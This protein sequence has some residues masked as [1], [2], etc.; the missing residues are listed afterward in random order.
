MTVLKN[1]GP[2]LPLDVGGFGEGCPLVVVGR[3][4]L[5]TALQGGGA[6]RVQ[7]IREVHIADALRDRMGSSVAITDG[8][9]VAT[10]PVIATPGFV[11]DPVT[12]APGI[13][14]TSLDDAGVQHASTTN[15]VAEVLLGMTPGPHDSARALELSASVDIAE[16]TMVEVGVRGAGHWRLQVA[17]RTWGVTL[18][19]KSTNMGAEMLAPP[20]WVTTI[21]LQPGAVVRAVVEL[22]DETI[23]Y[24]GLIAHPLA[25]SDEQ[26]IRDAV[27][28]A[29][30]APVAVVVVGLTAEQ[31]TEGRDKHTLSLPGR[32]NDLVS[33]VAAVACRTVVVVNAAT[34]VLMP[35][36]DA[37]EAVLWAGLPGQEGGD[38][39]ADVLCGV[40]EA[41]G[42]LVTTFPAADG[43][44]PAWSTTP[45]DGN[46]DYAEGVAV[47]YRGWDTTLT[48]P[49][50]WFGHGL[51]W[52]SWQYGPALYAVEDSVE[53]V[54][55]DVTNT[56]DRTG[57]EVVQIY[58][59]PKNEPVRLVG[60]TVLDAQPP[61]ICV[62]AAVKLDG[63]AMRTWDEY[64][65]E[66]KPIEGGE[67][68]I[69]RGLGDVRATTA[70]PQDRHAPDTRPADTL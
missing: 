5:R 2:L 57:R 61:G 25:I 56:G 22:P 16:A 41:S 53:V 7:A 59:R 40:T 23:R 1:D 35:W 4:A 45:Q 48:P 26:A 3:A 70:R 38:A 17:E 54:T 43:D 60:W 10:E 20:S 6:A 67:L 11:R 37:V 14:V 36:L 18:A 33:A 19:P 29:F 55:V 66:W 68:V 21:E 39:V 27:T 69:A 64:D 12:A 65:D 52:T 63:R 15:A 50:F 49:L 8:V 62:R 13:R 30:Q 9:T 44:G 42:R 46:L 51:G 34:P 28:A 24:A 47:G 31:E 32:Q 58:L